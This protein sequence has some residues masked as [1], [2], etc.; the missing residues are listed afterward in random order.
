MDLTLLCAF[1][2]MLLFFEHLNQACRG[3]ITYIPTV[4]AGFI[5]PLS[6]TCIPEKSWVTH[7]P[8]VSSIQPVPVPKPMYL[9]RIWKHFTTL[10]ARILPWARSLLY[11][12]RKTFWRFG[13]HET[14]STRIMIIY[15]AFSA[16]FVSVFPGR[17]QRPM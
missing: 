10:S 8:T 5:W 4:R 12:L 13:Q 14:A 9:L 11:S 16:F 6:K 3:D 1:C 7:F 2:P 17:D 15:S